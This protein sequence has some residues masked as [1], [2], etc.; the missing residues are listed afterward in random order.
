MN[1]KNRLLT[2]VITLLYVV[3]IVGCPMTIGPPRGMRGMIEDIPT[4]DFR[5]SFSV[6]YKIDYDEESFPYITIYYNISYSGLTFLK[7]DSLYIAS[8]RLNVN[9]KHEGETIVNKSIIETLKTVDYSKTVARDESFFGTFK[10]NVSTGKNE[11][12]L[13]LMDRNSDRRYVWKREVSVS[14]VS[15]TLRQE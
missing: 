13:M 6:V 5:K 4:K 2:V 7:G 8:F 9:I 10:E 14:Q 1:R 11:I 12:L 15:D 3:V